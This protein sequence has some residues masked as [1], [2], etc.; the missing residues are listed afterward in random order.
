MMM[1]MMVN[2][3]KMGRIGQCVFSVVDLNSREYKD[4]QSRI[5]NWNIIRYLYYIEPATL[6]QARGIAQLECQ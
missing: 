2:G 4:L 6:R 3:M 1:M 5:I